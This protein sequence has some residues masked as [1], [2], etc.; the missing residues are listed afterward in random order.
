MNQLNGKLEIAEEWIC[1]CCIH[2]KLTR[3]QHRDKEMKNMKDKDME[4]RMRAK[5]MS[6]MN[7]TENRKELIVKF[8][9]LIKRWI[10]RST[11]PETK[12][13]LNRINKMKLLGAI[14]V[15]ILIMS[16]KKYAI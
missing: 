1:R 7:S 10:Q 3:L 8:P 15:S 4:G 6:N 11:D 14:T 2:E 9:E 5:H 13:T 12:C 16:S